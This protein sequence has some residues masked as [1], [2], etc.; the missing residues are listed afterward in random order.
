MVLGN[1]ILVVL[2]DVDEKVLEVLWNV[3]EKV[4]EVLWIEEKKVL[5]CGTGDIN[6]AML[7]PSTNPLAFPVLILVGG[8]WSFHIWKI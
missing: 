5:G 1:R 3:E 8:K 4:L 6:T 7:S 2:W